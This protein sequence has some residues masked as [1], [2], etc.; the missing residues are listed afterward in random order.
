MRMRNF[1]EKAEL[2]HCEYVEGRG[3]RKPNVIYHMKAL[4]YR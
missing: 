2:C 3:S 1:S 4:F